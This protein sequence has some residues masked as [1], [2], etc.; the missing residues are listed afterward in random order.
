MRSDVLSSAL[1]KMHVVAHTFG[2]CR[3]L[4][5]G[6]HLTGDVT[7]RHVM[8]TFCHFNG[9]LSFTAASVQHT[10]WLRAEVCQN[11]V[12]ILPQDRLP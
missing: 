8:T 11:K 6:D 3:P 9:R 10:K 4:R 5:T 1:Y 2:F 12:E 7:Q